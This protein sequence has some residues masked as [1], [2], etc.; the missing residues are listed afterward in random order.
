MKLILRRPAPQTK[1]WLPLLF[2][3]LCFPAWA[4]DWQRSAVEGPDNDYDGVRDDVA[5]H[6]RERWEDPLLRFWAMEA[7]RATQAYILS[8]N[9]AY[10]LHRA[11]AFMERARRCLTESRDPAVANQVINRVLKTQLDTYE[12]KSLY[13][14]A[15]DHWI[16]K[17]NREDLP[18]APDDRWTAACSVAP[19]ANPAPVLHTAASGPLPA[20][21][22]DENLPPPNFF[23]TRA[24]PRESGSATSP[25]AGS[26]SVVVR[27]LTPAATDEQDG[28]SGWQTYT[29]RPRPRP[30]ETGPTVRSLPLPTI[31]PESRT[32][33]AAAG[34]TRQPAPSPS[35]T[36]QARPATPAVAAS[37]PP[38]P[39]ALQDLAPYIRSIERR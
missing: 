28:P 13:K 12:R 27:P 32:A 6:I 21:A 11:H 17:V 34:M 24:L 2:L 10:A 4:L 23:L 25:R 35:V 39:A 20:T 7:A 5:Q 29:P 30:A 3:A 19:G 26:A 37:A 22:T 9:N 38:L 18:S 33:A 1:T 8:Q 14:D 15:V 36:T 31:R 16:H